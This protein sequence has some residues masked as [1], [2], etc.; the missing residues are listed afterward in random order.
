MAMAR[1]ATA[2]A[3]RRLG[4]LERPALAGVMVVLPA[5]LIWIEE[6]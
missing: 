2:R 6:R 3:P 1:A 4:R 5:A